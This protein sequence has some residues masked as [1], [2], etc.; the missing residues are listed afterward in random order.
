MNSI[1][2]RFL[3]KFV[4]VFFDD[5][6]VYS[7]TLELHLVLLNETLKILAEHQ[8]YLKPSKCSFGQQQVEYLG[9]IVSAKEVQVDATKIRAMLEWPQPTSV[10]ELGGFLG[11]TGYYRKFVKDYRIIAAPLTAL[12]RKGQFQWNSQAEQVFHHLKASHDVHSG[13]RDAK[14]F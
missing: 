10:I 1:F 12:L 11:L 6:L 2:R 7:T 4:L 14:F 3:R 5:I 9:H 13:A 8:F